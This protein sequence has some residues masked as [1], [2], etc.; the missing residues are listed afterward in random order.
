MTAQPNGP[1]LSDSKV[2]QTADFQVQHQSVLAQTAD[3]TSKCISM[4]Q[5]LN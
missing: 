4:D 5:P 3:S 1:E 2:S